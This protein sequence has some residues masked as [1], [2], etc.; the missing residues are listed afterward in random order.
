VGAVFVQN[1]PLGFR[2]PEE[3][4]FISTVFSHFQ[5]TPLKRYISRSNFALIL[6]RIKGRRGEEEGRERE[7]GWKWARGRG[8]VRDEKS[9]IQREREKSHFGRIGVFN[10]LR[11]S[12]PTAQEFRRF[13]WNQ[14]FLLK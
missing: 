9:E 14:F 13:E 6:Q 1:F 8:E 2:E 7:R 11:L 10:S 4:V 3:S 12:F 5:D